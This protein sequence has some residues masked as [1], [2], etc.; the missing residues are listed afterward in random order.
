MN[1]VWNEL[2]ETLALGK[3]GKCKYVREYDWSD[4]GMCAAPCENCGAESNRIK[5]VK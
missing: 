1:A 2:N 4:S 5:L 3:C